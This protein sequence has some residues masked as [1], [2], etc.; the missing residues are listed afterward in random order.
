MGIRQVRH[1]LFFQNFKFSIFS[2]EFDKTNFTRL[3]AAESKVKY[4]SLVRFLS[5][6]YSYRTG[7]KSLMPFSFTFKRNYIFRHVLETFE[8]KYSEFVL[9]F[10][11]S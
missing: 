7:N 1:F 8:R 4:T 9:L 6:D 5:L 10:C 11:N 2:L 3:V